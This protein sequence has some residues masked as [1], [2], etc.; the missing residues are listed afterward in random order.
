MTKL[1][2]YWLKIYG[3]SIQII[4]AFRESLSRDIYISVTH[5]F[6]KNNSLI[7]CTLSNQ[8]FRYRSTMRSD[9]IHR[10]RSPV[11]IWPYRCFP[12]RR[13]VSQVGIFVHSSR[14]SA[15]TAPGVT[16]A[17]MYGNCTRLTYRLE[18]ARGLKVPSG[19]ITGSTYTCRYQIQKE[20]RKETRPS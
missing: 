18:V 13:S 16:A 8:Q 1:F 19:S 14:P 3:F 11:S 17:E 15:V 5:I 20:T 4:N 6:S 2:E 12:R 7:S 9:N 10:A